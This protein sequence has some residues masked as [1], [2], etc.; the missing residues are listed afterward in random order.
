MKM[1]YDW[2]GLIAEKLLAFMAKHRRHQNPRSKLEKFAAGQQGL[3]EH[4]AQ[5]EAQA[6][7][8]KPVIWV[9]AASLGE[10]GAARPVLNQLH[11]EGR[12]RIVLT[13]F[14]STGYEALEHHHPNVDS[15]YYL[16]LDTSHGAAS[17]LDSVQPQRVV[18]IISEYWLNYLSELRRR[19]IPTF[20]IS[21]NITPKAI[22]FRWYGGLYRQALQT[23]TRILVLHESSRQLLE[24]IG[25]KNV[26]VTGDPLFDNVA[27]VARTPYHHPVIERFA[28]QGPLFIAGSV[29]DKKDL[30]LVSTLANRHPEVRFLIVPH[31]ISE[32]SLMRIQSKLKGNSVLCTQ[33]TEKTDFTDTQALI[34]DFIGAL[35]Y[36]YRYAQ[37]A[38]VGGGFTPY[39]HSVIEGSVYGLPVAF[40]PRIE[41]QSTAQQ[42][43]ANDIGSVVR[44]A[45]DLDQWFTDL[46]DNDEKLSRI[47]QQS[48]QF[49]RHHEGATSQIV[50]AITQS[51]NE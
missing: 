44:S 48:Q 20:L 32:E 26:I 15:V 14:S 19:R 36:I 30:Y 40:G 47:R 4:I 3:L 17:F 23:Y 49:M 51:V 31:E 9:H 25:C 35:A 7:K 34:V 46:Q 27:T 24:K 8:D 2:A 29:S 13:F 42:L 12:W 43:L 18:F 28:Q 33:C 22:F 39:L 1:L 6:P 10:Y 41:R 5:Q 38:Y 16:P 21:A 11:Q 50:N 45:R 37:W